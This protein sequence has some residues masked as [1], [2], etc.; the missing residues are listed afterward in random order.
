MKK[1][2]FGLGIIILIIAIICI[3]FKNKKGTEIKPVVIAYYNNFGEKRP[4]K[5]L[6]MKGLDYIIHSFIY[7]MGYYKIDSSYIVKDIQELTKKGELAGVKVM[8]GLGPDHNSLPCYEE[9]A[10]DSTITDTFARIVS[11][12]CKRHKYAGLDLDWEVP[13][14]Q[15]ASDYL[16]FVRIF[17]RVLQHDTL[18]FSITL[19]GQYYKTEFLSYEELAINVDWINIMTYDYGNPTPSIC[20]HITPLPDIQKDVDQF[21]KRVPANKIVLGLAFYSRIYSNVNDFNVGYYGK[22]VEAPYFYDSVLPKLNNP[23][24]VKHFDDKAQVPIMYN[25]AK[26]QLI[27]YDSDSTIALKCDLMRSKGLRGVFFWAI[28]YDAKN[29]LNSLQKVIGERIAN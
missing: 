16:R 6:S 1:V 21:L 2:G 8:V 3:Q 5:D 14:R 25:K 28:D 7:P 11:R 13:N 29:H 18:L 15:N 4:V 26:H 27:S 23:N 9:I 24:W 19:P 17:Y 10:A 22:R 20:K 12:F